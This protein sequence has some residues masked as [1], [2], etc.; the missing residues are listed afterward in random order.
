S[1]SAVNSASVTIRPSTSSAAG[2]A[3]IGNLGGSGP[4]EQVVRDAPFLTVAEG[5]QLAAGEKEHPPALQVRRRVELAVG[6]G[7]KVLDA[8]DPCIEVGQPRV[9][10][11]RVMFAVDVPLFGDP[12]IAREVGEQVLGGHHAAR[13]EVPRHPIALAAIL[14]E[15]GELTM[16]EQ[17]RE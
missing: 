6:G 10:R 14:E 1:H 3:F 13:K 12:Q 16:A 8:I 4:L 17:M 9:S 7:Q 15:I 5:K 11:A 2:V